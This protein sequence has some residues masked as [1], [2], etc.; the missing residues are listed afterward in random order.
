MLSKLNWSVVAEIFVPNYKVYC[1]EIVIKLV[2][3]PV[4][5]GIG[6]CDSGPIYT[7]PQRPEPND[8]E[9]FTQAHTTISLMS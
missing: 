3:L 2:Y 9:L 4:F 1:I 7:E 5:Q 6:P 8:T